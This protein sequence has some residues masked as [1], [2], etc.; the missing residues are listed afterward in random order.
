MCFLYMA[1]MLGIDQLLPLIR[2][3]H[4]DSQCSGETAE[5]IG[6]VWFD[7]MFNAF[8]YKSIRHVLP[9]DPAFDE[10]TWWASQ[11]SIIIRSEILFRGQAVL[12]TDLL[13]YN[14]KYRPYPRDFD[15]TPQMINHMTT[16]V[17]AILNEYASTESAVC[18]NATVQ[19]W[20]TTSDLYEYGLSSPTL[21]LPPPPYHDIIAPGR[22]AC[23]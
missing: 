18:A 20:R 23:A 4:V 5:F 11:M 19:R 13:N 1:M 8:H 6:T 12:H 21:C 17:T 2:N 3:F 14:G 7:A 9:Y 16:N 22:Y 15:F 10:Q